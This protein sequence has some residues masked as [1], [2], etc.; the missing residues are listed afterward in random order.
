L[1][2]DRGLSRAGFCETGCKR[3]A[4]APD[5]TAIWLPAK[6]KNAT[7]L[8]RRIARVGF[9]YHATAGAYHVFARTVSRVSSSHRDPDKM[10]VIV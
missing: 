1:T 8:P 6:H 2:N 10:P 7:L 4:V 3:D 5:L 9:R